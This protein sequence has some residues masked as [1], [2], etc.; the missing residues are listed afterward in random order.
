MNRTEQ[1]ADVEIFLRPANQYKGGQDE[2]VLEFSFQDMARRS[3]H[4]L[5]EYASE[6][7]DIESAGKYKLGIRERGDEQ[8][9]QRFAVVEPHADERGEWLIQNHLSGVL[10]HYRG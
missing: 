4:S 8:Y 7:L 1:F 2:Q 9:F 6:F 10:R 3:K 5:Y